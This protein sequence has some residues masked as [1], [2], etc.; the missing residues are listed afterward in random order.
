MKIK[1]IIW[2]FDGTLLPL[3]PYDSEQTL[4]LYKL[5]E[6]LQGGLSVVIDPLVAEHQANLLA[7]LDNQ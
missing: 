5:D 3:S 2:D 7:S 4:T 6:I 1:T